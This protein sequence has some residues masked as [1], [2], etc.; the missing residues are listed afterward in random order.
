MKINKV[1]RKDNKGITLIALVITIIV[2][3]ILAGITIGNLTSEKGVIKEAHTAKEEAEKAEIEEQ[4]QLAVIKAEQKYRNPTLDNVIEEIKNSKVISNASQVDKT[5]GAVTSDL[6]YVIEGMLDDYIVNTL[7]PGEKATETAKNNYTDANNDKATIPQGFTVSQIPEEATIANGLVIYDI[8]EGTTV[9]WTTKNADGAYRVQTLYNQFVWI[10]VTTSASYARDFSYP[11]T[12]DSSAGTYTDTKYLPAGI[13]PAAD[14]AEKNEQAERESVLKY[15]GFYIGRYETGKDGTTPISKQSAT[16]WNEIRQTDTKTTAKTMYT[17]NVVKS[18]LC[19]GIQWDMV[20]K[21]VDGKKDAK[22]NTY[23]VRVRDLNRHTG[24]LASAGK[25]EYDKVQ[26]IYD[27]EGNCCEW[28]A[29]KNNT[30]HSFVHRGGYC[31]IY[32]S[33]LRASER[34]SYPDV[35]SS[36]FS[37]RSTL[38]IM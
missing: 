12:Y 9:D 17:S 13:Q 37:F 21:F 20:M 34:F 25:N 7:E 27:L 33:D 11:S 23:N 30:S 36:N 6:G 32:S 2:L 5:T 18:A 3:L 35:A 14:T 22:N 19:S 29:E 1:K 4:I 24:S 8:P 15:Q 26:N 16:V 31:F 10:P 28:V 38:Y